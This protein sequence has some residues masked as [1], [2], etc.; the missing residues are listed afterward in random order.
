M[1]R[2]SGARGRAGLDAADPFAPVVRSPGTVQ[3][4]GAVRPP[5]WTLRHS[6][7]RTRRALAVTP[8]TPDADDGEWTHAGASRCDARVERTATPDEAE[9]AA[10]AADGVVAGQPETPAPTADQAGRRSMKRASSFI[11]SSKKTM[12]GIDR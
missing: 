5:A 9:P 6:T 8:Q 3:V 2:W 7:A 4:E 1:A 10:D 11:A 12:T